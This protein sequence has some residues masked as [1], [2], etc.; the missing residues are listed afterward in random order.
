MGNPYFCE[1][2]QISDGQRD[3]EDRLLHADRA[4]DFEAVADVL[5]FRKRYI[6]KYA[7]AI[8]TRAALNAI[9]PFA[10]IIESGA[11]TGYWA[12]AV[13]TARG[14]YSLLRQTSA[15][16]PMNPRGIFT[17]ALSVGQKCSV[18]TTR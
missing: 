3:R 14:R 18:E 17:S 12:V 2:L 7:H 13:E 10:P 8:P 15:P 11:G 16:I 4:H 9:A 5:S 6:Q 1:W